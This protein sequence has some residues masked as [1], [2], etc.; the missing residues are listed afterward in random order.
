YAMAILNA[1]LY[2]RSR[3]DY[4][5]AE[6]W[7]EQAQF[8][9]QRVPTSPRRTVNDAFFMNTLA[10]VEMRKGHHASAE[11][12]LTEGIALLARSAPEFHPTQSVILLH[13]MARLH[14]ASGRSSLAIDDLSRLLAHLPSDCDA[15]LD[16][17][18][19]HQRAGRYATALADYD[20]AIRWE[21]AHV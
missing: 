20:M 5:A 11:Q 8:F 1:R 7:T 17:G 18:L 16:R 6:Y 21:P 2:D 14:L 13:N 4:D 19:I 12:K 9:M 15:W 10:L 3:H